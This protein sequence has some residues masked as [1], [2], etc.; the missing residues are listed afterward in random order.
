MAR[1]N[2]L[3]KLVNSS[4]SI[5]SF[6]ERY[7]VPDNISLRY[8]RSN[9]L[10]LLNWDEILISV[11]SVVEGGVRFPFHPLLINFLQTVNACPDQLSINVFR[12]VM[13]VVT[14]NRLLGVNLTTKD[15]LF[16]YSYSCP[17]SDSTTSC[18][19]RAKNVNIKLVNG[20][21]S[22]HKGYDNDWLVVAVP[23]R[24]NVPD[25]V[26]NLE[27]LTKVLSSNICIDRMGQQ[28]SAPLLLGYQP[29]IGN[30][31]DGPTVPCA[32]E[33]PV[34]PTVQ[35]KAQPTSVIPQ[36]DHS[37]LIPTREV[38]EMAPPI[39]AYEREVFEV[40]APEQ[41]SQS[42]DSGSAPPTEQSQLPLIVEVDETK[43]V[44]EPAPRP[45]IARVTVELTH[46]PS[47]SSSDDIWVLEMMVGPDPL[48]VHRTVLD[49][50]NVELFAKVAHALTKATC[51][52]R[53]LQAWDEMSSGRIF[54][55]ISQGLVMAAQ[56]VDTMEARVFHFHERMKEKEAEHTKALAEVM[57][58][59]GNSKA[60]CIQSIGEAREEG[61]QEVLDSS[62]LFLRDHTP[63]PYPKADLKD[64]DKE[65]EDEEDDEDDV[66]EAEEVGGEQDL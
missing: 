10:P 20:L 24:L 31:L 17:G 12:I 2:K 57:K 62:D 49:T 39:D 42:E 58:K 22:S 61:K 11:M 46:I 26:A 16:I 43:Q 6:K 50:S 28:R 55:H 48:F 8:C 18:H 33:T 38:F 25:T 66:D 40:I 37:D 35:F 63:L 32:Q 60:E 7:L 59:S 51:L 27:D 34:E 56:G 9:D 3:A 54:R 19:L 41:S 5:R 30:F 52:P 44:E 4:E 23:S 36:V 53:D 64:S 47:S 13:G 15:I 45:K 14:I 21:P 1:A 65:D 29:L